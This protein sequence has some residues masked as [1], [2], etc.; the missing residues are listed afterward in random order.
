M[1]DWDNGEIS[2]RKYIVSIKLLWLYL[3]QHMLHQIKAQQFFTEF[4]LYQQC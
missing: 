3:V 2:T 4:G 1:L